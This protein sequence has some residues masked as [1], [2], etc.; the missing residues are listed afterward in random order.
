LYLDE[1]HLLLLE[2]EFRPMFKYINTVV[3]YITQIVFLSATL[4][5]PLLEL[6]ERF[7][8]VV[9]NEIIRGSTTRGNIS[10]NI[11]DKS[12][13]N[14]PEVDIL[15][16]LL[17]NKIYP[18][19]KSDEKVIIFTSTYKSVDFLSK[20]LQI[21]G[22]YSIKDKDDKSEI[23]KDFTSNP[24]T[25]ALIGTSALEVGLDIPHV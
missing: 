13:D 22:Y 12:S 7:F 20:H 17:N 2:K 9:H 18:N 21:P 8:K 3:K 16:D 1:V 14:K 23:L 19:L 24:R 10:Y 15:I 5:N 11:I 6:L 4:P 25:R